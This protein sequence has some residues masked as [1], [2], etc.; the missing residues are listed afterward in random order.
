MNAL[1]CVCA[2]SIASSTGMSEMGGGGQGSH[3]P[4]P[5]ILVDQ[6]ALSQPGGANYTPQITSRPPPR[7]SELPTYPILYETT[8]LNTYLLLKPMANS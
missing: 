8:T 4:S 2:F 3:A 1:C 5:Q 6:L 7:F